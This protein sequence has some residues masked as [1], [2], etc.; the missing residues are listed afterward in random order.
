MFPMRERVFAAAYDGLP[1]LERG[2]QKLIASPPDSFFVKR[3]QR[4]ALERG[5]AGARRDRLRRAKRA[6]LAAA[7][8]RRN[9]P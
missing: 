2:P 1:W 8:R 3:E 4:A 9:R 6:K 7:S 5:R